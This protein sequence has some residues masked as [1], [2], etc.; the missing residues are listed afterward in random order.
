MSE[1]FS[2][3]TTLYVAGLQAAI[4]AAER[5]RDMNLEALAS[6]EML[7]EGMAGETA[8]AA[9]SAAATSQAGEAA[10]H[11]AGD[12]T[13]LGVMQRDV[14]DASADLMMQTALLA[15]VEQRLAAVQRDA[16]DSSADLMMQTQILSAGFDRLDTQLDGVIVHL[17]ALAA[18]QR[19]ATA[20]TD[21]A[22][23][24]TARWGRYWALTGN[25]IHWVISGSA[26][27][28]AV[29]L[30]AAIAAA[31]GAFVL[32]QGAIEQ[33]GFRLTAMYGA[34][35]ATAAMIN[36]TTGD[37]LGLGPRV[38]DGAERGQP[39]RVR[40]SGRLRE[41]G[42]R[43]HGGPRRGGAAGGPGTG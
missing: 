2:A 16:A 40:A 18:A 35:E 43:A 29:V 21:D 22:A 42:P 23:A 6:I 12:F 34:T 26:E 19:A 32:Y 7:Q 4:D 9:E 33:V 13:A 20:S 11:A 3:D 36:K 41:R 8:R 17:G 28:L 27:L 15:S 24:S 37:V 39:H 5:F 25:A 1:E 38:P 14:A 10:A 31:A 30:P